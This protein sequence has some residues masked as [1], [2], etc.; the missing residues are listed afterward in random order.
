VRPETFVVVLVGAIVLVAAFRSVRIVPQRRMDVVE[1]LGRYHRTL[2]PGYHFLV[3]ML[4][5]VRTK[6]DMREQFV[7]LPTQ[8]VAT[9]DSRLVSVNVALRFRVVDP[10]RA[11][12]EIANFLGAIE[13]LCITSI[14][15]TI[16]S[17]DLAR[18]LTSRAEINRNLV[19]VLDQATGPWGLR[20][21][22]VEVQQ[23]EPIR[24]QSQ[25]QSQHVGKD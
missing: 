14:R 1:R 19:E 11:T 9:L 20:V 7:T 10:V 25:G 24:A 16:S 13:Q 18:T 2:K 17:L 22:R 4:D 15:T 5:A 8:P 12:Y 23:L 3:P 21:T 6:V